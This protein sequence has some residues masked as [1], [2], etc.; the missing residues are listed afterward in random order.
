MTSRGRNGRPWQ[1]A[2]AIVV[3]GL[4]LGI[5]PSTA[6]AIVGLDGVDVQQYSDL[7]DQ[8]GAVGQINVERSYGWKA[9]RTTSNSGS[10]TLIAPD[11]VLTGAHV[12]SRASSL[13]FVINGT[14]YE[15][16]EWT[17]YSHA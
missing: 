9:G 16:E 6:R 12:L 1:A 2:S 15:V 17:P 10:G 7:G 4:L 5:I 11:V 3:V 14:T 13:E 8:F